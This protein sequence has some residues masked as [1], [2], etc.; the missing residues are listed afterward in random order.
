MTYRRAESLDVAKRLL[1]S[2]AISLLLPQKLF[3]LGLP[4]RLHLLLPCQ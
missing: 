4:P 3:P 2:L 1:Q